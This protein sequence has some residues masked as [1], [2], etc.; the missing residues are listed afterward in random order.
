MSSVDVYEDLQRFLRQ[1]NSPL[2]AELLKIIA[3]LGH[4]PEDVNYMSLEN[5]TI[6]GPVTAGQRTVFF[7]TNQ[8]RVVFGFMDNTSE[9]VDFAV[10]E[11]R[12]LVL[13]A[14]EIPREFQ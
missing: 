1:A 11:Q 8:W 12:T 6:P 3:A 5:V 7:A 9:A 10:P 4:K 13:P 14:S 2:V